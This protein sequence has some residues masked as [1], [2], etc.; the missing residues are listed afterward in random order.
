MVNLTLPNEGNIY[1]QYAVLHEPTYPA[2]SHDFDELVIIVGGKGEHFV[3]NDTYPIQAGDV[4]VLKGEDAHGFKH[5][6]NLALYNIR[7]RRSFIINQHLDIRQL[8]GFHAL[9]LL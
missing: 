3:N 8:A 4:F 9:F 1:V 6:Q 2:H 5:I 7:Y